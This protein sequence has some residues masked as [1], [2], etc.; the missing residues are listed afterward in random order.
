M[1]NTDAHRNTLIEMHGIQNADV[2][3]TIYFDETNNIAKLRLNAGKLNV[4]DSAC[5]ALGGLAMVG[6]KQEPTLADLTALF[7]VTSS[8]DELKRRHLGKGDF[9]AIL[10]SEKVKKFLDWLLSQDYY[11]HYQIVDPLYWGLVDIIDNVVMELDAPMEN[12]FFFGQ[13]G[14]ADLHRVVQHNLP[15]TEA[16]FARFDYPNVTPANSF[17]FYGALTELVQTSECLEPYQQMMLGGILEMGMKLVPS[18]LLGGEDPDTLLSSFDKF[19]A[20]RIMLF[21]NAT[22]I[23]DNETRISESLA[24]PAYEAMIGQ[25]KNYHF[26]DSKTNTYIQLSDL[27]IGIIGKYF[28]FLNTHETHEVE[29]FLCNISAVQQHNLANLKRLIDRSDA[30]CNAFYH[31]VISAHLSDKNRQV[32]EF[33]G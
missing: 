3:Y 6:T 32:W 5:F 1:W 25:H 11:L 13:N 10:A 18:G 7:G 4:S 28:S 15:A 2:A 14:K 24:G 17:N 26:S 29:Q 22:I 27:I 33:L 19:Y 16:I 8:V 31:Y 30:Q 20:E 12:K 23:F 9:T 21:K